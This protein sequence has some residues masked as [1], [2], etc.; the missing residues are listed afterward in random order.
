MTENFISTR[1]LQYQSATFPD[2]RMFPAILSF[3]KK[4]V[5]DSYRMCKNV[6]ISAQG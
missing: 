1:Q 4:A 2:S 3:I 6:E 5:G